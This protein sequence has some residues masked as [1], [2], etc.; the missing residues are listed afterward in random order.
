MA[1]RKPIEIPVLLQL[2]SSSNAVDRH[3]AA[4]ALGRLYAESGPSVPPLTKVAE[5]VGQANDVTTDVAA[6][7]IRQ[8]TN[9]KKPFDKS[10]EAQTGTTVTDWLREML[11][12]QPDLEDEYCA[13][14]LSDTARDYLNGSPSVVRSVLKSGKTWRAYIVASGAKELSEDDRQL[15]EE[16]AMLDDL[17]VACRATFRLAANYQVLH[18]R[19]DNQGW[20]AQRRLDDFWVYWC[21]SPQKTVPDQVWSWRDGMQGFT[22]SEATS[23]INK[24]I[25]P[26]RLG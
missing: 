4:C 3:S 18:A 7:F 15:L 26:S 19:A 9:P 21:R 14:G 20:V 10:W 2:L 22:H 11:C 16:M 13:N 24:I 25:H 5:L 1:D 8:F 23:V 17:A 12:R 6:P